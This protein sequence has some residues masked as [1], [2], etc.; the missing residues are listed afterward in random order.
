MQQFLLIFRSSV[1]QLVVRM[2]AQA[3]RLRLVVDLLDSNNK[4][5]NKLYNIV[6][7]RDIVDMLYSLLYNMLN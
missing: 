1:V 3:P 6:K 5:H 2:Q 7:R 4:S